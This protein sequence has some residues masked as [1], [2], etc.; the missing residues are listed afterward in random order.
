MIGLKGQGQFL[1]LVLKIKMPFSRI[2]SYKNGFFFISLNKFGTMLSVNIIILAFNFCLQPYFRF[3]V[4]SIFST[5]SVIIIILACYFCLQHYFRFFVFLIFS[6]LSVIWSLFLTK[7]LPI[8]SLFFL[9][10]PYRGCPYRPRY[11]YV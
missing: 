4:F 10:C 5:L 3:F 11:L 2:S 6:T 9:P 7:N 8:L 1:N